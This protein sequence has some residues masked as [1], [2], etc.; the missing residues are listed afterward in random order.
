MPGMSRMDK[1]RQEEAKKHVSKEKQM[2]TQQ[3]NGPQPPLNHGTPPKKKRKKKK[4]FLF[5]V[6]IVFV[7]LIGLSGVGYAKG[8]FTA[9][10]DKDNKEFEMTAFN[11]QKSQDDSINILLLGSDSRGED[12]GRSDSIMIAHYNKKTKQP[13]I[14]SIM[15]D[16]F[17]GIPTQD[18]IEYN[19]I[20]AAYSYGGP[21][22]VRQTIE[23]NFGVSIQ[24]YAVVNFD[25]FPKII[26]VLAPGGLPLTAEK[27]LEV[28]GT[29][30][31]KGQTNLS[32]HEALQYARF[33]KDEEGDFGRVRRQQQVMSAITKQ[34]TNPL[35]AWKLPEMLGAVVGYTQTDVPAS[36]YLSVG[37][38]YLFSSHKPLEILTV[39]VE[40]SWNDGYYDYAGSVLE[41]NEEM[42]KQAIQKFFSK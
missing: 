2:D 22:M 18:G 24:Y 30:I 40:G 33:R 27:D 39:P 35:H 1:R 9:K 25:S 17:V 38:S 3:V 13:Q 4:S 21:E 34:A 26:D 15:R 14:V 31:K 12:Q 16:T 10:V 32:G 8:Y 23:N 41:I 20:N 29:V 37:T 42:N 5:W 28:E 19:K 11:G 36:T 7:A 6:L